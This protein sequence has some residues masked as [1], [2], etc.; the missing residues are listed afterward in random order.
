[1]P[2]FLSEAMATCA[3]SKAQRRTYEDQ[4]QPGMF[5]CLSI[6]DSQAGYGF[7]YYKN[8]SETVTLRETHVFKVLE[9]Y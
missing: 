9:H 3:I 8:D 7:L 1:M 6:H 4:G 5:R 2:E